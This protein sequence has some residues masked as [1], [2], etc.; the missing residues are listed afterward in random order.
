MWE[1]IVSLGLVSML[2]LKFRFL[3]QCFC[4]I[5]CP[6]MV[7][8]FLFSISRKW[9]RGWLYLNYSESTLWRWKRTASTPPGLL[10]LSTPLPSLE[11]VHLTFLGLCFGRGRGKGCCSILSVVGLKSH[12]RKWNCYPRSGLVV[13]FFSC[14]NICCCPSFC[15]AGHCSA[16]QSFK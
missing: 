13:Q 8:F 2:T 1:G 14:A 12:E 3:A 16:G 4:I 6:C 11:S 10:C 5:F 15:S 9:D 7:S